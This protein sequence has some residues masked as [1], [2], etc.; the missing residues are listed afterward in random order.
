M[1]EDSLSWTRAGVDIPGDLPDSENSKSY[2][3]NL[4]G[5]GKPCL[6]RGSAHWLEEKDIRWKVDGCQKMGR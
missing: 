3:M 5:K 6:M 4:L 2:V 1:E